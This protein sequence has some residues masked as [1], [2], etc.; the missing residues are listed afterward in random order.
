MICEYCSNDHDGSYG[1]GRFCNAKCARGFS[2]KAK[3]KEIN[4]KVGI[5]IKKHKENGSC[6]GKPFSLGFDERRGRQ[7]KKTDKEREV[8]YF[9]RLKIKKISD[10]DIFDA[11]KNSISM[12]KASD[13]LEL[14][15]KTLR[16]HAKRL[17]IFNPNPGLNGG[18]RSPEIVE[19]I[20][21]GDIQG[22]ISKQQLI[23]LKLKD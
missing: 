13:L 23:F 19:S 5:K 12:K 6:Q 20:L 16:F 14:D 7:E 11:V 1:S 10:I 3:R 17:G 4:V 8:E 9:G 15:Y 18:I 21:R 22:K 2:T